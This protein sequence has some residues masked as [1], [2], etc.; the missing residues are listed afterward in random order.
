VGFCRSGVVVGE[1]VAEFFVVAA[2]LLRV[3]CRIGYFVMGFRPRG[4][5][6]GILLKGLSRTQRKHM[7][8]GIPDTRPVHIE[9]QCG[10]KIIA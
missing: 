4:F 7:T 2:V 9:S 1:F 10:N 3:F 5:V 8:V 6:V